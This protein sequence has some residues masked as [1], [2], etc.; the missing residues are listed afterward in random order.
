MDGSDKSEEFTLVTNIIYL[1]Y[2]HLYFYDLYNLY[3]VF[4]KVVDWGLKG[5]K[6]SGKMT[7]HTTSLIGIMIS[8]KVYRIIQFENNQ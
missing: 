1:K 3:N 7:L 4:G 6:Y 2:L 8:G 5:E